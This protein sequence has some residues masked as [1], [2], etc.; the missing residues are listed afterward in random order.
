MRA[1]RYKTVSGYLRSADEQLQ[2]KLP[3]DGDDDKLIAA[4]KAGQRS[5][6]NNLPPQLGLSSLDANEQPLEGIERMLAIGGTVPQV[7]ALQ[8]CQRWLK[9]YRVLLSTSI[10]HVEHEIEQH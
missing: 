10:T 5:I 3:R 1:K 6:I 8:D 7:E 2:Y 9:N 4:V